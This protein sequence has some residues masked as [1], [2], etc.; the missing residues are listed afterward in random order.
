MMLPAP[1]RRPALVSMLGLFLLAARAEAVLEFPLQPG[2]KPGQIAAGPDGALWF[3]QVDRI[4]RVTT[5]GVIT[6][7]GV[8]AVGTPQGIVSGPDGALW[9][10]EGA[11]KRIGRL[12]TAGALTHFD[13]GVTTWDI[14]AGSDGALW[15][16]TLGIDNAVWR[17]T[18]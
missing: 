10:T 9:F 2:Q 16:T 12:T 11:T 6:D 15:F 8:G 4:G 18:P 14:A 13:V 7:Y 1:F 5:G 3:T 17:L